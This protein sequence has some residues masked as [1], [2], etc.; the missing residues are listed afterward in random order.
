MDIL[1]VL[2]DRPEALQTNLAGLGVF[3]TIE[4]CD[5]IVDMLAPE[6]KLGIIA[7]IYARG[8]AKGRQLRDEFIERDASKTSGHAINKTVRSSSGSLV[9]ASKY[10]GYRVHVQQKRSSSNPLPSTLDPAKEP[11]P[12]EGKARGV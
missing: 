12:K 4:E 7:Q 1:D 8:F 9:H 3:L 6:V 10:G 2:D 11:N 5:A